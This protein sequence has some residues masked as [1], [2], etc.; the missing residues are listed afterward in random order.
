MCYLSLEGAALIC[1]ILFTANSFLSFSAILYQH[2]LHFESQYP[3]SFKYQALYSEYDKN[4]Q[5]L[6]DSSNRAIK[7]VKKLIWMDGISGWAAKLNAVNNV[8]NMEINERTIRF[9]NH[10]NQCWIFDCVFINL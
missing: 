4:A 8:I 1:V 10:F 6:L 5:K 7:L 2:V 9:S 3:H